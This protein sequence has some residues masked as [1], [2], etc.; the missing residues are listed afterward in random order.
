MIPIKGSFEAKKIAFRQSKDGIVI[1]FLIHPNDLSPDLAAAPL[2]IRMMVGYA[3]IVDEQSAQ[4]PPTRSSAAKASYDAKSEQGKAAQR[5]AILCK[6]EAF[7]RFI[8][9][10]GADR[11]IENEAMAAEWMRGYLGVESRSDIAK[12]DDAFRA[13][14]GVETAFKEASGQLPERRG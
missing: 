14:L 12:N 13:F 5:A 9:A 2:G 8:S 6:D 1:S 10:N 4:E 3:E 7:W 11:K